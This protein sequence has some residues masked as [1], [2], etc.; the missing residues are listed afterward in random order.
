MRF[1]SHTRPLSRLGEV[2]LL[3]NVQKPTQRVKENK[4]KAKYFPSKRTRYI[5]KLILIKQRQ[6]I[7]PIESSE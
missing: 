6:V 1:I 7:Y 3:S 5:S 2:S 4:E